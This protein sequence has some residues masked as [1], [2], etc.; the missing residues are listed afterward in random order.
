VATVAGAKMTNV[1][2]SIEGLRGTTDRGERRQG[3]CRMGLTPI[4]ELRPLRQVVSL[5]MGYGICWCWDSPRVEGSAGY[6]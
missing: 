1:G 4:R 2:Q 6:L 3:I 5:K